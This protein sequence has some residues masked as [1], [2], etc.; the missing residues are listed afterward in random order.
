MK[1]QIA[2]ISL[3]VVVAAVLGWYVYEYQRVVREHNRIVDELVNEGAYR[4]AVAELEPL[5]EQANAALREQM[6]HTLAICYAGIGDDPGL[7]LAESARWY[8]KAAEIDP[9]LLDDMQRRA[10]RAGE[11]AAARE[12]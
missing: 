8:R 5:V 10:L 3:A 4:E 1:L 7:S 11:T 2:G 9:E 6:R 12:E